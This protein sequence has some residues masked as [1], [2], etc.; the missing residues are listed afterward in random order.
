MSVKVGTVQVTVLEGLPV[1]KTDDWVSLE[2]ADEILVPAD[3][4]Y[5]WDPVEQR[6]LTAGEVFPEGVT[7][8][9][10]IALTP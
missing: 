8:K 7:V 3:A 9:R 4:W 1:T 2:F 6:F 10:K 5:N